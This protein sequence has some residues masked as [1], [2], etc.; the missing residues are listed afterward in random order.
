MTYTKEQVQSALVWFDGIASP[1]R[2]DESCG[3]ILASALR[4]CQKEL[5]SVKGEN[6]LLKDS[7]HFQHAIKMKQELEQAKERSKQ[8]AITAE[9]WKGEAD[10]I[11]K[12]LEQAKAE[13]ARKDL[14]IRKMCRENWCDDPTVSEDNGETA[15][16]SCHHSIV[17]SALL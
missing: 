7:E 9:Q 2:P 3:K 1:Y 13:I 10:V 14:A 15:C 4:E 5:E 8:N 11:S 12:Q 6:L 17:S 16:G